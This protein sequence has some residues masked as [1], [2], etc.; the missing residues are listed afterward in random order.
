MAPQ[1]L[2]HVRPNADFLLLPAF[3]TRP[4]IAE[5]IARCI[6][7]WSYLENALAFLFLTLLNSNHKSAI[8]LF[9]SFEN[10]TAKLSAIRTLG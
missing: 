1:P 3:E 7:E 5:A 9:N 4:K 8:S 2:S 10:A 6:A